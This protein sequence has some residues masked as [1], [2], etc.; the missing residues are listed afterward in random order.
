MDPDADVARTLRQLATA[1][2]VRMFVGTSLAVPQRR[3]CAFV[4]AEALSVVREL[5]ASSDA[6]E[7]IAFGSVRRLEVVEEAL[8]YLAAGFDA[9]A[10]LSASAIAPPEATAEAPV[11]EWVLQRVR[12]LLDATRP[13]PGA[14]PPAAPN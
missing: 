3:A 14:A 11:A 1:L 9:N 5:A 4:A 13:V 10:V 8:L 7:E 6:P 12:A 2:E